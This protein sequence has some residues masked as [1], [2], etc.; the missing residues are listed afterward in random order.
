LAFEPGSAVLPAPAAET[1][2]AFARRRGGHA[3]VVTGYGDADSANPD[4]QAKALA[5]G[6]QRAQAMA[7]A[8]AA[9]GVPQQ[10]VRIEAQAGGRGGAARIIE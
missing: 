1:L 7:Q 9:D 6:L 5:L 8:L 4:V 2:R 10:S 3:I